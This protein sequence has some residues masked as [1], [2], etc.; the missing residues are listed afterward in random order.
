M[1]QRDRCVGELDECGEC[2][3][4]GAVFECGCDKIG[5]DECDCEGNVLDVVG[6]CGGTCVAD[7]DN[8][9]ICDDVDDCVGAI[10]GV[11]NGPGAIYECGCADIPAEIDCEAAE[12]A[13]VRRRLS[14]ND[15]N[16]GGT[17]EI[18]G[19]TYELA[20]NYDPM[21]TRDDGLCEFPC[22]GD[23]NQNVF[24]WDGD[25]AVTIADFLAMLSVFGDVDVDTDG[26]GQ[27]RRMH[28]FGGMQLRR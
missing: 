23:I 25:S 8:D 14:R 12:D 4:P 2:N 13:S 28:G 26:D 17:N 27:Q 7:E 18:L 22:S 16:N 6:V 11:C 21:A 19:C 9:G 20:D 3:G 10:H 24:D 1:R 15:D 5:D